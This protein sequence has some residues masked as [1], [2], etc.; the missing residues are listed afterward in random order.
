MN[1]NTLYWCFNCSKITI[2][3]RAL[4]CQYC[5]CEA[6]EEIKDNNNPAQYIPHTVTVEETSNRQPHY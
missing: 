3:L 5:Q 4:K 6:I 2:P 1:T